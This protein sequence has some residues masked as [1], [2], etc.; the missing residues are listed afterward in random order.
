MIGLFDLAACVIIRRLVID[1][2]CQWSVRLK[3]ALE[4]PRSNTS[5]ESP[6]RKD[7]SENF[8]PENLSERSMNCIGAALNLSRVTV[9]VHGH[10]T[11]SASICHTPQD[12]IS[13]YM[14]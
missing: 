5:K 3:S 6:T 12:Y 8:P 2:F 7:S 4:N 13:I 9:Q 1:H 14:N 10:K 11:N